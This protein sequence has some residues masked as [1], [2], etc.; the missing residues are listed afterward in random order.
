MEENRSDAIGYQI[1]LI[2]NQ[3]HKKMKEK[4]QKKEGEPLTE[5][6][7]WTLRYLAEHKGQEVYQKDIE[8]RF[9]ISRATAS[10]ILAVMERKGL[11]KRQAAT[12][13]ARLKKL[14][15]TDL[16]CGM[17]AEANKDIREM[18]ALIQRGLTVEEIRCLKK[19]LRVILKNLGAEEETE[20]RD[21]EGKDSRKYR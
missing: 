19:C 1:R 6:Q 13:D 17:I 5:M 10:N 15:L 11:I 16:A 21:I 4:K 12:H 8:A 3:I 20:G 2:H 9:C 14:V 18:E 7:R